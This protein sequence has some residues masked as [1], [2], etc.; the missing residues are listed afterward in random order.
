MKSFSSHARRILI[1][2]MVVGMVPV[3]LMSLENYISSKKAVEDSEQGHLGYALRSRL[4][5]L[6][7][8]LHHTKKEFFYA[9]KSSCTIRDCDGHVEE[10]VQ[11]N[12]TCRSLQAVM[13]GHAV[14][15][16]LGVFDSDWN[17]LV[18]TEETKNIKISSPNAE[19]KKI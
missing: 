2:M 17:L 10:Q 12:R 8:W 14:Y 5:F 7:A 3:V 9:S 13:R 11:L 4:T 6:E 1:Y 15:L 18:T 19:I 16:S